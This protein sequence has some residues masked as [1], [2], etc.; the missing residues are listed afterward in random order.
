MTASNVT[1]KEKEILDMLYKTVVD[2]SFT[3]AYAMA[4]K[5]FLD[6][7]RPSTKMDTND[8]LKM[9]AYFAAG[10]ASHEMAVKKGW[11]P[12]SIVPKPK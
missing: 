1:P 8:V 3:F 10:R 2:L 5:K 12:A 9:V 7:S 4:G 6:I 11:L